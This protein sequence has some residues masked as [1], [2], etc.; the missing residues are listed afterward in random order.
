MSTLA[1]IVAALATGVFLGV[2]LTATW[3]TSVRS[4][5]QERRQRKVLDWQRQTAD[6]R[7]APEQSARRLEAVQASPKSPTGR[8][9]Q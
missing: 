7:E 9:G 8:E 3:M 4:Y 1:T 6:A 2:V 5:I